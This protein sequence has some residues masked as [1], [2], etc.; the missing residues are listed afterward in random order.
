MVLY[1]GRA[2]RVQVTRGSLLAPLYIYEL[3]RLRTWQYPR[4]FILLSVSPM[5]DLDDHVLDGVGLAG[6]KRNANAYLL[7]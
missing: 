2:L 7:A 6:F 3:A 1:L 4:I 5:N